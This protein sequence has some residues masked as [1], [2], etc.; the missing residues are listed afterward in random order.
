[1]S[2]ISLA[3]RASIGPVEDEWLRDHLVA[4]TQRAESLDRASFGLAMQI[5]PIDWWG[6][7]LPGRPST[8]Q[9]PT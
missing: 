6:A 3:S 4:I 2:R 8:A 7:Q 1:L 9:S 5:V